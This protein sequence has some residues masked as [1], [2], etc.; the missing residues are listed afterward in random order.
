MFHQIKRYKMFNNSINL[1]KSI[2]LIPMYNSSS[3]STFPIAFALTSEGFIKGERKKILHFQNEFLHILDKHSQVNHVNENTSRM[4]SIRKYVN[5]V[6]NVSIMD[7]KKKS[8]E[9]S[10][11]VANLKGEA[12][13]KINDY[14]TIFKGYKRYVGKFLYLRIIKGLRKQMT[15]GL[16]FP[17]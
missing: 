16:H 3:S 17:R 6:I 13:A 11:Q 10:L 9:H 5:T 2:S 12:Q 4:F 8:Q 14:V 1:P 7:S 15:Q